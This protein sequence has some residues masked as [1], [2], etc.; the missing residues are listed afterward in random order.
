MLNY[1]SHPQLWDEI[2]KRR[3]FI[4]LV[5]GAAAGWPLA[6]RA[7]QAPMRRLGVLVNG[8]QANSEWQRWLSAF[9]HELEGLGWLEGSNIQIETRFSQNNFD[10][11]PQLARE[12]VGL[13]PDAIFA[14][15]TPAVKAL[16]QATPTIPIVFVQ[17]SDPTG[18]GVVASLARP[19]ASWRVL[20][21]ISPAFCFMKIAS[22]A[23]GSECSRRL[24]QA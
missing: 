7:Q 24:R 23:N 18:S 20:A 12:I 1:V 11:L 16:Q 3:E 10:S 22:P 21:A 8:L 13:N 9:R 14:T 17:V 6:A 19:G 2:M 4:T 15:T 5:G